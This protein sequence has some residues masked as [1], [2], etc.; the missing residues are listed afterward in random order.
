[1]TTTVEATTTTSPEVTLDEAGEEL[2]SLIDDAQDAL[3]KEA[4]DRDALAGEAPLEASIESAVGLA[5]DLEAFKAELAD[6]EV[7]E[8]ADEAEDAIEELD[9]AVTAYI[10]VL[11]GYEGISEIPE[12]NEQYAEEIDADADWQEA[13]VV[14]Q[15]AFDGGS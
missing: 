11:V 3:D 7:P 15:V 1:M 14:A 13:V 4:V 12:Y 5:D 6:I 8:E 2:Q 9:D 10:E